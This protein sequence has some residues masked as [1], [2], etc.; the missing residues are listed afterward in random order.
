MRLLIPG[1]V[2]RRVAQPE[3]RAHVD[4]AQSR[5]EPGL[6]PGGADVV[7]QA[8]EDDVEPVG[9]RLRHELAGQVEEGKELGVRLTG[10]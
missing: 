7:G 2:L 1:R 4:H 5:I 8:A 10:V 3:I 9:G 6:D